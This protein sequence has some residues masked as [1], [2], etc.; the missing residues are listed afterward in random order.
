MTEPDGQPINK[1]TVY[2]A[3]LSMTKR[4]PC[5]RNFAAVWLANIKNTDFRT[6]GKHFTIGVVDIISL[7]VTSHVQTKNSV[8]IS[9][10]SMKAIDLGK[11]NPL[12]Q[13]TFVNAVWHETNEHSHRSLLVEITRCF[14][15]T[16]FELC[17][18]WLVLLHNLR[19]DYTKTYRFS[20]GLVETCRVLRVSQNSNRD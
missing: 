19:V 3:F 10:E 1:P 14:S 12:C 20:F 4:C 5:S 8:L 7:Q 11:T 6:T 18:E 2:V 15:C 9:F 17:L 16:A 13:L